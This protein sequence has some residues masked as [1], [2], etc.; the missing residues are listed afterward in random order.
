MNGSPTDVDSSGAPGSDIAQGR[1][2]AKV[3][4]RGS[5]LLLSAALT[6]LAASAA[7]AGSGVTIEAVNT[8][9]AGCQPNLPNCIKNVDDFRNKMTSIA[10]FTNGAR[11]TEGLVFVSDFTEAADSFNFDRNA[12]ADAIGYFH[13][14]GFCDDIGGNCTTSANCNAPPAGMSLPGICLRNQET[15]TVAG[16]CVYNRRRVSI[17]GSCGIVDYTNGVRWGESPQS[18]AFAGAGTDGG[19][20][21]VVLDNSCGIR[22]N[23]Y[24]EELWSPFAGVS[25]IAL[26]MPSRAGDDAINVATRG[27]QFAT[28]YTN[29][30]NSSIAASWTDA[31]NS[32][33]GRRP[34]PKRMRGPPHGLRRLHGSARDLEPGYGDLGPGPRRQQ[35]LGRR[36]AVRVAL[37]L[38][39]QL[40]CPPI[41]ALTEE[42]TP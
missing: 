28:R 18:G 29:N 31:I 3:N 23:L 21:F 41:P 4:R 27:I 37:H 38:Q 2:R 9:A 20:N 11:W 12:N 36:R 34:R 16:R 32:V 40:Q 19:V 39:L 33:S 24:I 8:Y 15:P 5:T 17:N 35:R 25:T 22:P 1:R 6:L 14:H 7:Q 42:G 30:Q 13:S 10:G 26:I